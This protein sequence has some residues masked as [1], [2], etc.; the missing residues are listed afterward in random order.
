MNDAADPLD[1]WAFDEYIKHATIAKHDVYGAFFFFLRDT[2]LQFCK[3]VRNSKT[4]FHIF[5]VDAI[6][7]RT[8]FREQ[9]LNDILFD[10]IE[11]NLIGLGNFM[12]M[13]T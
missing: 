2:L 7:I 10:R 8:Y 12:A 1:G 5:A 13:L 11:V 9:G 3:R 6:E 4:A